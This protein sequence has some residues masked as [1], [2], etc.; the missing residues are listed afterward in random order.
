M[1]Y[2]PPWLLDSP[3]KAGIQ[4]ME[5]GGRLGLA[6]RDSDMREAQHADQ[7]ALSYSEMQARREAQAQQLAESLRQHNAMEQY[8]QSEIE[9]QKAIR[10]QSAQTAVAQL[11]HQQ[12][13]QQN[14][15]EDHGLR[16]RNEQRLEDAAKEAANFVPGDPEPIIADGQ[17]LGYR[18]QRSP[19]VYEQ[20]RQP[21]ASN[22]ALQR[23]YIRAKA[24]LAQAKAMG[25]EALIRSADANLKVYSDALNPTTDSS[26]SSGEDDI[27]DAPEAGSRK[28]G[29][30]YRTP[31]GVFKWTGTGWRATE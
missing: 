31:K 6:A 26:D 24:G 3:L 23:D 7:L 27:P 12:Q 18:V 19:R 21:R 15:V 2:F 20:V 1:P 17:T 11:L 30:S 8:R 4:T 22:V 9:N 25:D 14:W 5:A 13:Q 29:T 28:T 10:A 16:A